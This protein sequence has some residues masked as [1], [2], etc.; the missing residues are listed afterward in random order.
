MHCLVYLAYRLQ[1]QSSP[2]QQTPGRI[3][4][5]TLEANAMPTATE[6]LTKIQDQIL[7]TIASIQKPVVEGVEKLADRAESVVPEVPSVPG[8]D[9]LPTVNE[10]VALQFV[11]AEKILAQQKDFTTALL[12]AIKPVSDK[13]VLVE[14][15]PKAKAAA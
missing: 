11:F 12:E 7:E 13:V 2:L 5:P 10:I 14:A 15:K 9:K 4:G 6:T 3:V 1:E 8:S